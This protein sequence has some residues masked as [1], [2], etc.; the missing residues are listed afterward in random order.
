MT[1]CIAMK[2]REGL[3]GL[4][5]TRVTSGVEASTAKKVST[6]HYG[7]HSMFVMT[8]GLR[9]A[10]DKALTY[11][12]EVLEG[13][14]LKFDKLYKAV[15]AFADQVRRV[16]AEDKEAL[17]ESNLSFNLHC[18]IGG[19][20]EKDSDHKLYQLYPQA[21]WV[22]VSQGT[23]YYII[24]ES[25]YGKSLLDRLLNYDT[26]LQTAVKIGYLAFEATR[27][28]ATDVYFPIDMVLYRPDIN[29]LVQHRYE[30]DDLR[31]VGDWWQ[32][33]LKELLEELPSEWLEELFTQ[34][35]PSRQKSLAD[36]I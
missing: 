15:N 2:L 30:L 22:E 10:R 5:D 18:I 19:Q 11:F 36:A 21:N 13:M 17:K 1:F 20:L 4:S 12:D 27:K 16:Y 25:S 9:S 8:S 23:P 28:A 24:G 14:D 29:K 31:P 34:L 33:Q 35:P 26:S 6:Y 32:N 3:V 7:D